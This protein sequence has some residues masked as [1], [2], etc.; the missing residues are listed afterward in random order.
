MRYMKVKD[1]SYVTVDDVNPLYLV[2][3]K[4]NEYIEE[5]NKNKN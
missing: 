5:S 2:V 3:N 4:I 1:L